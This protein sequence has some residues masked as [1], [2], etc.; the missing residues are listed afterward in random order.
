METY[1]SVQPTHYSSI[2]FE[3]LKIL[4]HQL[5]EHGATN[6]QGLGFPACGFSDKMASPE[7]EHAFVQYLV[8]NSNHKAN[9]SV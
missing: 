6:A 1:P 4:S 5:Q 9:S 7:S 3:R 8:H 2:A